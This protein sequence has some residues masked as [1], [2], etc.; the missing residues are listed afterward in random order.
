MSP[1]LRFEQHLPPC[2]PAPNKYEMF[3]PA[4]R[5]GGGP[6]GPLKGGNVHEVFR[7]VHLGP[8]GKG[9]EGNVFERNHRLIHCKMEGKKIT[10][11]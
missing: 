8:A 9:E 5:Q 4:N 3:R 2:P 11:S 7:P 10:V 6:N 1:L